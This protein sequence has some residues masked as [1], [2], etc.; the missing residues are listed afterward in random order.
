MSDPYRPMSPG[1]PIGPGHKI[2]SAVRNNAIDRVIDPARR[3][4]LPQPG[5]VVSVV[6]GDSTEP[7]LLGCGSI[8][9]SA[10]GGLAVRFVSGDCTSDWSVIPSRVCNSAIVD[11][12]PAEAPS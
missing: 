1:E 7:T 10:T 8:E 6:G 3:G 4:A 5:P 12:I 11:A 2:Y 9:I